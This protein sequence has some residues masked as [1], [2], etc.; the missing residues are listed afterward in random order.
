HPDRRA[1]D[2]RSRSGRPR[3]PTV[4]PRADWPYIMSSQILYERYL[5]VVADAAVA[6]VRAVVR[7]PVDQLQRHDLARP[8]RRQAAVEENLTGRIAAVL[9][10]AVIGGIAAAVRHLVVAQRLHR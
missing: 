4:S 1:P 10:G 8:I 2:H 3:P 5:G 9:V 7:A 6:Q